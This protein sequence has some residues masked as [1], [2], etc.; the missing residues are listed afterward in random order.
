MHEGDV[1]G[2]VDLVND[3]KGSLLDSSPRLVFRLRL[4]QLIELVRKGDDI[5]AIDFARVRRRERGAQAEGRG[6]KSKRPPESS[7]A[8]GA[9]KTRD[10]AKRQCCALCKR[11]S[12]EKRERF[13]AR[14]NLER[15]RAESKGAVA[16]AA[17]KKSVG[18]GLRKQ[19]RAGTTGGASRQKCRR[20]QG[21]SL[22]RRRAGAATQ[23]APHD[24]RREHGV[25]TSDRGLPPLFPNTV[26][27]RLFSCRGREMPPSPRTVPA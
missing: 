14:E 5:A 15:G 2:A 11:C 12:E 3:L 27:H 10:E 18:E 7:T 8:N 20:G 16:W 4:Q 26:P 24:E 19:E 21:S 9:A 22:W 25:F 23:K 1:E 13:R 6:G 17:A